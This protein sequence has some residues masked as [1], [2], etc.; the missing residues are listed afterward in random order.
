MTDKVHVS[1]YHAFDVRF[2][3]RVGG[4]VTRYGAVKLRKDMALIISALQHRRGFI[5]DGRR[6]NSDVQRTP[7]SH[8]YV[9]NKSR[10]MKFLLFFIRSY[11]AKRNNQFDI[12][13]LVHDTVLYKLFF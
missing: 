6:D 9:W 5:S 12:V 8:L 10:K 13:F 3:F 4:H 7:L 11:F 2:I 1:I